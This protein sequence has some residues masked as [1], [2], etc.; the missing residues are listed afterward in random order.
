MFRELSK[1]L[2][3]FYYFF[4]SFAW[5]FSNHFHRTFMNHFH[6]NFPISLNLSKGFQDT[7]RP[8]W[9]FTFTLWYIGSS[10]SSLTFLREPFTFKTNW[11]KPLS[12]N[13]FHEC[14]LDLYHFFCLFLTDIQSLYVNAYT[15]F[16]F[17]PELSIHFRSRH[18]ISEPPCFEVI[19]IWIKPFNS[20]D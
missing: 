2:S 20:R 17:I 13:L 3:I 10:T 4:F 9:Y 12:T 18:I 19:E 16:F 5:E 1:P 14:Y 6:G 15:V 7:V 8:V 11:M